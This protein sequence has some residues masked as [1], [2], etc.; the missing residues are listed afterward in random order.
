M[1][2]VDPREVLGAELI[3]ASGC[4]GWARLQWVEFFRVQLLL[5]QMHSCCCSGRLLHPPEGCA[6]PAVVLGLR[7]RSV[8]SWDSGFL[9]VYPTKVTLF[10]QALP[11]LGL[12][13]RLRVQTPLYT[14]DPICDFYFFKKSHNLIPSVMG[15]YIL[16]LSM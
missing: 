6:L 7:F 1:S 8:W 5:L 4:R 13:R 11:S 14:C 2:M 9:L 16:Y 15:P 10:S 3:L 12:W